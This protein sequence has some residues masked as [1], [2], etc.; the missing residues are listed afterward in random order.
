MPNATSTE[1][2]CWIREYGR[3]L[4]SL[5]D[6]FAEGPE[7]GE[8]IVQEVWVIAIAKAHTRREDVPIGAWL[9]RVALNVGRGLARR[10]SRR[11][12]LL[13]RWGASLPSTDLRP[14][15]SLRGAQRSARVWRAIAELPK[16]QQE[17]LLARIDD[18]Q[19]ITETAQ[20]L[21]R[22]EGT[23]KASLN[24]ACKRLR[25]RLGPPSGPATGTISA[26]SP[27]P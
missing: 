13:R 14:P 25:A 21:G 4:L 12:A 22:A 6:A 2:Q 19:S 23:V 17:V 15:P 1:L 3:S 11:A 16:L 5:A 26:F 8:D 10:R 27:T 24:Q 9:H 20:A 18:E 7:E